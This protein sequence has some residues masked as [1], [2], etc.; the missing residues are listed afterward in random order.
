MLLFTKYKEA[1]IEQIYYVAFRIVDY[2]L[3]WM[4]DGN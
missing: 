4:R 1:E 2:Q 3:Q